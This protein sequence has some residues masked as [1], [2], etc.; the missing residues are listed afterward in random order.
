ME[1][2]EAIQEAKYYAMLANHG[3]MSY[4]EAKDKAQPLIDIFNQASAKIAR[5]H[6]LSA[7]KATF[8][9]IRR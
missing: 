4:E 6:G 9:S 8:A 7:R 5:K 3:A 1:A 2:K